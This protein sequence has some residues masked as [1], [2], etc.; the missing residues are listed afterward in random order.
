MVPLARHAIGWVLYTVACSLRTLKAFMHA[1]MLHNYEV[2]NFNF[3]KLVTAAEHT[4]SP[5][6]RYLTVPL[7]RGDVTS[8]LY[9]WLPQAM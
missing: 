1:H 4:W 8:D 9:S 5:S 3:Y 7:C 2:N 6:I